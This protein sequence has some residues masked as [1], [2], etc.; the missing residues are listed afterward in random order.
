MRVK[1]IHGVLLV[2]AFAGVLWTADYALD[3]GFGHSGYTKVSP[4][5]SGLVQ[6]DLSELPRDAVQFYRFINDGNQEVFFL[7]GR[8]EF[9]KVHVGFDA[10]ETH[11][12]THRGF[13]FQDGWLVDNKCDSSSRL[14]SLDDAQRGGCKPVPMKH[15]LEGD[16]LVITEDNALAGW[17]LFR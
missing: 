1:P 12:K 13:S 17:R 8:D 9:G 10:S 2:L 5:R 15:R 3:G 11:H 4:D 16:T 6:I 14:S 7:V